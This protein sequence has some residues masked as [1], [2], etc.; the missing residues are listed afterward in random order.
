[1]Q[2]KDQKAY[3][4]TG[5]KGCYRL[6]VFYNNDYFGFV[7]LRPTAIK[8]NRANISTP[9]IASRSKSIFNDKCIFSKCCWKYD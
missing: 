6:H 9:F 7:T 5:A 8:K 3:L 4:M 1:M 2:T